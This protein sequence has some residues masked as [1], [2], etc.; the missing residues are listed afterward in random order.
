[1]Q[2]L[3][4]L[5]TIQLSTVFLIAALLAGC[6][7]P[8]DK[9]ATSLDLSRESIVVI[10]MRMTNAYRPAINPTSLG[11]L[12]GAQDANAHVAHS[13]PTG[14]PTS[15]SPQTLGRSSELSRTN[16]A[17]I[18]MRLAPGQY[19]LNRLWGYAG[20]VLVQAEMNYAVQADFVVPPQAVVYLGHLDVVNKER[21]NKDDQATG[22]VIPLIPQAVAGFSG[23][24][25]DVRLSDRYERDIN[26]LKSEYPVTKNVSVVRAAL[27]AIYLERATGSG[28]A[29]IK[30]LRAP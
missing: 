15:S 29:P 17:L 9:N 4:I 8:L 2:L 30:V 21:T 22:L 26:W 13:V 14:P 27:P 6:A 20:H 24:T 5:R 1:M 18:L 3:S 25:L 23:G 12:V 7:S 16:E 11:V 28:A 19:R 10:T